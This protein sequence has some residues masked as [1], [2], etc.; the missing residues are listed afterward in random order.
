MTF[1]LIIQYSSIMGFFLLWLFVLNYFSRTFHTKLGRGTSIRLYQLSDFGYGT[2]WH[3]KTRAMVA[4]LFSFLFSISFS[5][6]FDHKEHGSLIWWPR[7]SCRMLQWDLL[8]RSKVS[9]SINLLKKFKNI[10]SRCLERKFSINRRQ[11]SM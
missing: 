9:K 1:N 11:C 2:K 6:Y 8:F 3:S 5:C 4:F 7:R 10:S